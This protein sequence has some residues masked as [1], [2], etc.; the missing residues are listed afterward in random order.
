MESLDCLLLIQLLA[1][2]GCVFLETFH[3]GEA[4]NAN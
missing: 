3:E 4:K 1:E 2:R